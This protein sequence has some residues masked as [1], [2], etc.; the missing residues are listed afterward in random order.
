MNG[1]RVFVGE[2]LIFTVRYKDGKNPFSSPGLK[3]TGSEITIRGG[4]SHIELA[5]VKVFGGKLR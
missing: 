1:L 4:D 5:E 2:K 3:E